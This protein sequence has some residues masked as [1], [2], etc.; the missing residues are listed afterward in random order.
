MV[1][2][3]KGRLGENLSCWRRYTSWLRS[4]TATHCLVSALTLR[5]CQSPSCVQLFETPWSVA[6]QV[7]LSMELSRQEYCCGVPFPPPTHT[8]YLHQ[9]HSLYQIPIITFL[10]ILLLIS[11]FKM[12]PCIVLKWYLVSQ[13]QEGCDVPSGENTCFRSAL[14]GHEFQCS[15]P[16]VQC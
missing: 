9:F 7:P 14:F 11:L 15:W 1:E 13:V 2:L 6:H 8:V 4:D 16:R 5:V 3:Y 12:P 10:C